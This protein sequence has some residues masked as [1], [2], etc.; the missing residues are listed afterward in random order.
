MKPDAR[1][2]RVAADD[3]LGQ[4]RP[5]KVLRDAMDLVLKLVRDDVFREYVAGRV[6]P[7]T[8]V[9]FAF[10]L[11]STVCSIDVMFRVASG[12]ALWLKVFSLL[13]G[14]VVW[15]GGLLSQTYVFLIWLEERAVQRHR[16]EQGIRLKLPRGILAY[17]K[18]SR[19]LPPWIVIALCVVLPLAIMARRIPLEALLLAA[20]A[21]LAPVVFRNLDS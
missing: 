4:L 2:L 11:V 15:L 19:A 17:L 18:Y 12:S 10:F 20:L 8:G 1:E 7:V 14:S 5:G 3:M 9:I 13:V 21:I 6:W 16:D